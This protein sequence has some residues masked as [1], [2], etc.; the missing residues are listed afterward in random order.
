MATHKMGQMEYSR[1]RSH[2]GRGLQLEYWN[3]SISVKLDTWGGSDLLI[4]VMAYLLDS[5]LES[6]WGKILKCEHLLSH[7]TY[8]YARFPH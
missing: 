6:W 2:N 8:L 4:K 3:T 5:F 1:K 7:N